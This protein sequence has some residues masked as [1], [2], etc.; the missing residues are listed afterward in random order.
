MEENIIYDNGLEFAICSEQDGKEYALLV[1][2]DDFSIK[3]LEIPSSIK[4]GEEMLKVELGR[5]ADNDLESVLSMFSNLQ[6]ISIPDQSTNFIIENGNLYNMDKGILYWVSPF[7]EFFKI[8]DS[9]DWIVPG[10]FSR[11]L[12][13]KVL[14]FSEALS[15]ISN[16]GLENCIDLET[17]IIPKGMVTIGYGAFENCKNLKKI[18]FPDTLMSIGFSAFSNCEWLSEVNLPLNLKSIESSAFSNCISLRSIKLPMTIKDVEDGVF[19]NCRSIKEITIPPSLEKIGERAFAHCQSLTK[20]EVN[21]HNKFFSSDESGL[22]NFE[23]TYLLRAANI[24]HIELPKN[25]VGV[26]TYAFEGC[27]EIQS[28][29]I[30]SEIPPIKSDGSEYLS[31]FSKMCKKI[32]LY[33][34]LKSINDYRSHPIWGK[35]EDILPIN[36]MV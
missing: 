36:K 19:W 26:D 10:A 7:L 30:L 8:P 32:T 34:P 1:G 27:D 21:P 11:A 16:M 2:A 33:V 29:T 15:E 25:I 20:F 28:I 5:S 3:F 23:K 31:T 35:V 18:N 13:L 6:T 22:F 12:S 17:V 24:P 4:Y 9:V 14:V